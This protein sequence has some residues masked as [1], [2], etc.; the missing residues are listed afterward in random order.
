MKPE[1]N[2]IFLVGNS[3]SRRDLEMD[4]YDVTQSVVEM[5]HKLKFA[6]PAQSW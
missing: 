5:L 2:K 3:K 1:L 6:A 4:F